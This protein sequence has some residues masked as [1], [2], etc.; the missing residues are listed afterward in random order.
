VNVKI[1]PYKEDDV[2]DYYGAVIETKS[3]LSKWLPWCTD[4]YSYTDA[5]EWVEYAMRGERSRDFVIEVDGVFAG[6]VSLNRIDRLH[7]VANIGY[8]VRK[9]FM[10]SGVCTE[11]VKQLI[12][13]A[14]KEEGLHRLEIYMAV[15]N[16]S[17]VRV[18]EKVADDREGVMKERVCCEGR[19][20][21]AYLFA[22]LNK[23]R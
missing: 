8:W 4:D 15:D 13:Y 5:E 7:K 14:F 17:A 12:E 20:K 10:S 18:A 16:I 1:R 6:S 2:R 3:E 21:D 9:S 22:V 11:A 19:H 23:G